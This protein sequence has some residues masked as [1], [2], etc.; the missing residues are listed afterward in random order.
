MTKEE[1]QEYMDEVLSFHQISYKGYKGKDIFTKKRP[2]FRGVE[3]F[4]Y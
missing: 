1:L 4:T 2:T 3:I